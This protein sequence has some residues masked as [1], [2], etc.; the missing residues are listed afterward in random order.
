MLPMDYV[1]DVRGEA[2]RIAEEIRAEFHEDSRSYAAVSMIVD[3]L[4]KWYH[5]PVVDQNPLYERWVKE[6]SKFTEAQNATK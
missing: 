4:H 2:I 3:A 5:S 1:R 6:L